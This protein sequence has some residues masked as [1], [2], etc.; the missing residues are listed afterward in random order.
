MR[1]RVSE[2]AL[3]VTIRVLCRFCLPLLA[4]VGTTSK[5]SPRAYGKRCKAEQYARLVCKQKVL[6]ANYSAAPR[7]C[8]D[9][10][11]LWSGPV[12]ETLKRGG[13]VYSRHRMGPSA[14]L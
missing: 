5:V 2:T 8:I 1:A 14:L 3:L 9:R 4:F 6:T 12:R 7:T 10:S 13:L 11:L